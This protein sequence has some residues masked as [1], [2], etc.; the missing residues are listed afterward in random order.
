MVVR[1]KMME[2]LVG[3]FMLIGVLGFL[4][5][6]FNISGLTSIGNGEYY[7]VYAEFDN[8]GSL[9]ARAPVSIAG[10][11]IGRV[12]S[13]VLDPKTF[14]AKVTM[15]IEEKTAALPVD[16]SASI[17]T[18][19]LLGSNYI[20]LTP[21]FEQKVLKSGDMIETTHSALILENLIGQLMYNLK[22]NGG[23]KGEKK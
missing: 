19:G 13:I 9:K 17:L 12:V 10:V 7:R 8:I 22:G 4:V 6:A 16:T 15:K 3:L 5:L 18:Q 14:R 20:S 2:F 23:N 1:T 21:G 11:A